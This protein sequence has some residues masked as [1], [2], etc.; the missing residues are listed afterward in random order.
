MSICKLEGLQVVVQIARKGSI[1]YRWK[2]ETR[3]GG[4]I[5]VL[6]WPVRAEK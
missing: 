3:F 1:Q 5:G 2:K 4:R 6:E